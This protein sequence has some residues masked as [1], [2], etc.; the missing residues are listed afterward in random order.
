[1]LMLFKMAVGVCLWAV[2]AALAVAALALRPA[3]G[4]LA[5]LAALTRR[6]AGG[7]VRNPSDLVDGRV[8]VF[9]HRGGGEVR[10]TF[11]LSHYTAIRCPEDSFVISR[12]STGGPGVQCFQKRLPS[13]EPTD[14]SVW[15]N[16]DCLFGSG[17]LRDTE[18]R[19]MKVSA[20]ENQAPAD[21]WRKDV[22]E[23]GRKT[24]WIGPGYRG[25]YNCP[26]GVGH[27]NHVHGCDGCCS[28]PDFPLR[29]K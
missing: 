24:F 16:M 6:P 19:V 21:D 18:L 3:S 20:E 27:G 28:R 12:S 2:R 13:G 8:Y 10:R 5:A 15:I 25:E 29:A 9:R 23:P 7:S 26:H 4:A 22:S 14:A 11:H 17:P 1:M